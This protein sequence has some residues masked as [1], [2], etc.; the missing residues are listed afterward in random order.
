MTNPI[1]EGYHSVT[2]YLAVKNAG[3]AIDWYKRAFGASELM[4]YEDQGKVMHAEIKIGDSI[5]MLADEWPDMG[6]LSPQTLGN[7]PVGLML[8]VDDVDTTFR[9]AV[10]AGATE[11]RPL[12]DQFYGDRTGTLCDP[13]G[14]RWTIGTHVED[15]SDDEMKQRMEQFAAA[16]EQAPA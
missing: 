13:Y 15:V 5:V 12:A 1:P 9:R 4:R 14:H 3:E 2:P 11:E 7:T 8:Y 16:K 6:H 10:D